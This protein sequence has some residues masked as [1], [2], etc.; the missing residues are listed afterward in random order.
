MNLENSRQW[1]RDIMRREA[2]SF[3]WSTRL[4]PHDKRQAIEALYGF[5]R[6]TDD[7]VD[8]GNA[9]F[10]QRRSTLMR[11]LDTVAQLDVPDDTHAFPWRIALHATVRAYPIDRVQLFRV[12]DGCTTDLGDVRFET[13]DELEDY[14]GKVAGSVGR[15]VIAVLGAADDDSSHRAER[16]GIAMQLTNVVRDVAEDERRG[17]VYVPTRAFSGVSLPDAMR[18]IAGRARLL[19]GEASVLARRV[20]NDGSRAALLMASACYG[21]ILDRLERR[22]YDPAAGRV[23]VGTA[24]KVQLAL[25]CV[26]AAHT[27]FATM[28]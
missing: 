6:Y 16:L 19:Y 18:A 20:P 10:G 24:A 11:V 2:K 7:V 22:N 27:G 9:S 17:R 13:M 26:V 14:G 21:N 8:E 28:R 23:V 1:C 4:L 5:F 3:F 12:I 25:R 15:C